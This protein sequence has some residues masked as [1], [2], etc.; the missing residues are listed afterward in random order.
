MIVDVFCEEN[1]SV[2]IQK[3]KIIQRITG[4]QW[5]K[6]LIFLISP[7]PKDNRSSLMMKF[8]RI[9]KMKTIID[10]NYRALT[11][12]ASWFVEGT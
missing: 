11:D 10:V 5:V 9:A 4:A 2:D 1:V 6:V 8:Y 7:V 12:A 3:I